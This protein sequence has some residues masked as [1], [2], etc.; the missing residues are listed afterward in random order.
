MRKVGIVGLSNPL[1][2]SRR[3]EFA[4][5]LDAL[6]EAG[7]EPVVSG[8]L[9]S[10]GGS[11][12]DRAR[13]LEAMWRDPSVEAV[14]DVTGGDLANETLGHLDW[15]A[16]AA[17]DKPLWGYSDLTCVLNAILARTGRPSALYTVWN[18][19]RED[20]RRQAR[21]FRDAMNG[22]GALFR[23]EAEFLQGGRMAGEVVG[24]NVRCLLKLAGTPFWPDA[25][26]KILLLESRSGGEERLRADFAQ[27]DQM[28]AFDAAAGVLLGTFTE[29]EARGG[30]AGAVDRLKAIL[31]PGKPLARTRQIGHGPDSRAVWIGRRL[32]LRVPARGEEARGCG[33]SC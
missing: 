13:A 11:P 2:E 24:G 4:R 31:G 12:Q 21:D 27:L 14:F 1:P 25:R 6:R 19:V 5:L 29:L 20:A 8:N 28:G 26:G 33:S 15:E 9:F 16:A 3:P 10:S 18:L 17:A 30:L 22:G 32:E 23:F 7:L